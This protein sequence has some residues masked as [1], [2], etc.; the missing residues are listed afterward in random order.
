MKHLSLPS[1]KPRSLA[2]IVATAFAAG[3]LAISSAQADVYHVVVNGDTLSSIS[4]RYNVPAETLRSLN[5]LETSNNDNLPQMLL[6]IPDGKE[7]APTAAL[8]LTVAPE[9]RRATSRSGSAM[10]GT[11]SSSLTY[12]VQANDSWETI[13][14]AH[15]KAG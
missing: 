9:T 15:Q 5:K 10:V 7:K 14:A 2:T 1:F 11:M 3:T 8:P 13:A 12:S 4:A 6:R